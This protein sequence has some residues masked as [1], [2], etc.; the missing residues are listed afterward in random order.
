MRARRKQGSVHG[1]YKPS[2]RTPGSRAAAR[3]ISKSLV[4]STLSTIARVTELTGFYFLIIESHFR[5][6]VFSSLWYFSRSLKWERFRLACLLLFGPV[7]LSSVSLTYHTLIAC[8][9][10]CWSVY[11]SAYL[12]VCLSMSFC[13]PACPLSCL[14][15]C[16]CIYMFLLT[17]TNY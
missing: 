5:I 10:V 13:L 15:A 16:D 11:Q 8:L 9:T 14:P 7:R 4:T 3:T 6:F 2:V 17:W 1:K 12:S